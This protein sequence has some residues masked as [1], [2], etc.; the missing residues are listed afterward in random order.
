[1]EVGYEQAHTEKGIRPLTRYS[2]R[3]VC[4]FHWK[5]AA[6]SHWL[7]AVLRLKGYEDTSHKQFRA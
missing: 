4:P 1:M 6:L 7:I 5:K 2:S 3:Y